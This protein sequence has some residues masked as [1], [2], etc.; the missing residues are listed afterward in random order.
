MKTV[1]DRNSVRR[2][3]VAR[4]IAIGAL[5]LAAAAGCATVR[6]GSD[7]DRS[8]SFGHYHTF[9]MMQREHRGARNPLVVSR[10]QDAITQE[11][12]RKGYQPASTPENADFTVDFTIGSRERTDINTYPAPY[13]G[14]GWAGWGWGGGG[15]WGGPYW[16]DQIDVRQVREGTLSIDV[17]DARTHRPVWHGW[18]TKELTR[19]DIEQ[20]E[21]PI[22]K[23]VAAILAKFPPS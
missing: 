16:G 12:T 18:A 1:R 8:A 13:A 6:V 9:T 19:S 10:A 2:A 22:R 20:S 15:W 4:L 23:A 17:F 14:A 11:L 3:R 21:Q 7:Y 5:V